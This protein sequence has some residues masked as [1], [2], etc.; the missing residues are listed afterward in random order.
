MVLLG[1]GK[2]AGRYG[3]F[4]AD[5][6]LPEGAVVVDRWENGRWRDVGHAGG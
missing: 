4:P 5:E 1:S 6:P 2:H 3:W